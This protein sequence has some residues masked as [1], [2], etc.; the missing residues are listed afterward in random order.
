MLMPRAMPCSPQP[1]LGK[2]AEKPGTLGQSRAHTFHSTF[3][4]A[5]SLPSQ[6]LQQFSPKHFSTGSDDAWELQ[7]GKGKAAQ[8][9]AVAGSTYIPL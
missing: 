1:R 4:C 3:L 6:Q 5:E 7:A 9:A 2:E 8:L